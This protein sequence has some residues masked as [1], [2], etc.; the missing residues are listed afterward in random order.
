MNGVNEGGWCE[1]EARQTGRVLAQGDILT[2]EPLQN[3]N[4]YREVRGSVLS[5]SS[6]PDTK[7]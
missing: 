7:D 4:H 1:Q 6:L 2:E 5:A 3:Q